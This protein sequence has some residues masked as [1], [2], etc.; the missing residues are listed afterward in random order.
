MEN[1]SEVPAE[2]CTEG[3]GELFFGT[4][5]EEDALIF[6]FF[7]R[8]E[9]WLQAKGMIRRSRRKGGVEPA[10]EPEVSPL[11]KPEP[12]EEEV[13]AREVLAGRTTTL[14][15]VRPPPRR[16]SPTPPSYTNED[17]SILERPRKIRRRSGRF[18][19][20]GG[21]GTV[22]TGGNNLPSQ[23][24]LEEGGSVPKIKGE[25][26]ELK[27]N[28][29]GGLKVCATPT[30]VQFL[31]LKRVQAEEMKPDAQIL[32]LEEKRAKIPPSR[33]GRGVRSSQPKV[34][35]EREPTTVPKTPIR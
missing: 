2:D 31:P 9:A 20:T 25:A 4:V 34:K 19:S 7:C 6:T 24:K 10:E 16:R 3:A 27:V 30:R 22:T 29:L 21:S 18:E 17:P 13:P 35:A 8:S 28:E 26:R 12:V 14:S 11:P 32:K 5:P 15:A 33:T 23:A 1:R